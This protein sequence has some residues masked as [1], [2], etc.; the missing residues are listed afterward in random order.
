MLLKINKNNLFNLSGG[1]FSVVLIT[2]IGF[3]FMFIVFPLFSDDFMYMKPM[4]G[5]FN[6]GESPWPGVWENIVSHYY[7]DN[8]RLSNIVF[9]LF[10]LL[11]KWVGCT[12]SG[13]GIFLTLRMMLLTACRNNRPV[14]VWAAIWMC[15]LFTFALPWFD[16]IVIMCFQFNY[17]W[18]GVLALLCLLV[19]MGYTRCNIWLALLLGF[20]TGW[21]HEGFSI[22]EIIGFG[23]VML[24]WSKKY[25]KRTNMILLAGLVIGLS[26][27]IFAPSFIERVD[28]TNPGSMM[29]NMFSALKYFMPG[30]IFTGIA[31]LMLLSRQLRTMVL[32]PLCTFIF[33]CLIV[34]YAI[35]IRT[36]F[37]AHIGWWANVCSV[38]GIVYLVYQYINIRPLKKITST[39][40]KLI[41]VIAVFILTL[42]LICADAMTVKIKKETDDIL[43]QYAADNDKDRFIIFTDFTDQLT[44][45]MLALQKPYYHLFTFSWQYKYA[46]LRYEKKHGM[47]VIPKQLEFID[48]SQGNLLPGGVRRLSKNI[49][50]TTCD[51]EYENRT[52]IGKVKIRGSYKKASFFCSTFTSKADGKNYIYIFPANMA[53]RSFGTNIEDIV[54]E[55]IEEPV[56]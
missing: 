22:P 54:I 29:S 18:P 47:S 27:I 4:L 16:M 10:L 56:Y 25:F 1:A 26:F 44:A 5:Y 55:N 13:I 37:A 35:Y 46:K 15:T 34:N 6:H 30:V 12:L 51:K 8:I 14:S 39:V 3:A 7:S 40:M 32:T 19:F 9:T 50:Y 45:P 43:T 28:N 36:N 49:Y 20:V 52:A 41:S 53:F 24:I 42:H 31:V 33:V 21:W 11:P 2:T 17:V 23:T 38:M 48:G